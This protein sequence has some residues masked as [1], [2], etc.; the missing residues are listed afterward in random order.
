MS[1]YQSYIPN[2]LGGIATIP[3]TSRQVNEVKDA[4]NC[5]FSEARGCYKR[6]GTKRIVSDL[7]IED[8]ES[9]IEVFPVGQD[10]LQVVAVQDGKAYVFWVDVDQE[11]KIEN[12]NDL[13]KYLENNPDKKGF[14]IGKPEGNYSLV[15]PQNQ[16]LK[17]SAPI[18]KTEANYLKLPKEKT[19]E[20]TFR[21]TKNQSRVF[22]LNRD[23][24]V[25][26]TGDI[27]PG[28]GRFKNHWLIYFV[29][30]TSG[31]DVMVELSWK[32]GT[33]RKL[34]KLD[35]GQVSVETVAQDFLDKWEELDE[36]T[37]SNEDRDDFQILAKER[38][39]SVRILDSEVTD[40][41][42]KF[43]NVATLELT[44]NEDEEI[45]SVP[46]FPA[47]P[48]FA[49]DGM[50]VQVSGSAVTKLDDLWV[51]FEKGGLR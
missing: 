44:E 24:D 51:R 31:R 13:K 48:P 34:V 42:F 16:N 12:D 38:V 20:E 5:L 18:I 35:L 9:M 2:F 10:V 39:A 27:F 7:D 45:H 22:I 14:Y 26:L 32:K 15:D 19:P 40:L 50:I 6:P 25:R 11:N 21:V 4:E 37:L 3:T 1:D 36:A 41:K 8:E 17:L 23:K 33:D 49:P 43:R 30:L 28:N 29:A 47:L 46:S